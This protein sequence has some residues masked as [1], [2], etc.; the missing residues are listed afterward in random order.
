MGEKQKISKTSGTKTKKGSLRRASSTRHFHPKGI[1]LYHPKTIK[2]E[3]FHP[4]KAV[5]VWVS[6]TM[7]SMSK[8]WRYPCCGSAK[9][10]SVYLVKAD[11]DKKW[12]EQLY[13]VQKDELPKYWNDEMHLGCKKN[14]KKNSKNM[15]YWLCCKGPIDSIGC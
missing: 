10:G 1:E 15:S 8:I 7:G 13:V 12:D 5:E 3:M 14:K 2:Y 9:E 4:K 11:T 6:K